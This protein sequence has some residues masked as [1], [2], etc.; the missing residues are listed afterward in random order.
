MSFLLIKVGTT[1]TGTSSSVGFG[2][3][4]GVAPTYISISTGTL[5]PVV[6]IPSKALCV[7]RS[8]LLMKGREDFF[9]SL[10]GG[11]PSVRM[12]F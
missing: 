1:G 3:R 11:A 6:S 5:G 2:R 9:L 4:N 7:P 12:R 10:R 8:P